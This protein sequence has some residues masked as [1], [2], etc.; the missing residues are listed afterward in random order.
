MKPE[1]TCLLI[2]ETCPSQKNFINGVSLQLG[3]HAISIY[4]F[5]QTLKD[6]EI[7]SYLLLEYFSERGWLFP[8][9]CAPFHWRRDEIQ[10]IKIPRWKKNR[11]WNQKAISS[12]LS[13]FFILCHSMSFHRRLKQLVTITTKNT[14]NSF[15][16]CIATVTML[17]PLGPA[18][19]V[20][21]LKARVS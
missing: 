5:F 11:F 20:E 10:L 8:Y 14:K 4:L 21:V 13:G 18:V 7:S 17:R 2:R 15:F 9:A 16:S 1:T 12:A 3:R 19:S 6:F